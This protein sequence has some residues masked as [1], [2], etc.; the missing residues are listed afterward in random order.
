MKWVLL[1]LPFYRWENWDIKRL[2]GLPRSQSKWQS[3]DSNLGNLT[4]ESMLWTGNEKSNTSGLYVKA[5]LHLIAVPRLTRYVLPLS[6]QGD[7]FPCAYTS[8]VGKGALACCTP[9]ITP[10]SPLTG[11]AHPWELADGYCLPLTYSQMGSGPWTS[12]FLLKPLATDIEADSCWWPPF[13]SFP[14]SF[15]VSFTKILPF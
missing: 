8:L 15:F 5:S 9:T 10:K 13:H 1:A 7:I 12:G 4:A 6:P 11:E 14:K 2:S 3:W